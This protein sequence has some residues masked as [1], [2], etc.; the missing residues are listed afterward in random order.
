MI[1][2]LDVLGQ[3]SLFF[4]VKFQRHVE[5][6]FSLSFDGEY[7]KYYHT[8][9]RQR[10]HKRPEHQHQ[11]YHEGRILEITQPESAHS[12]VSEM[13]LLYKSGDSILKNPLLLFWG[14]RKKPRGRGTKPRS[15]NIIIPSKN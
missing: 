5:A 10:P 7:T 11:P 12:T 9:L 15:H 6:K 8:I 14:L 2:S 13:S 3:L 1:S 4:C